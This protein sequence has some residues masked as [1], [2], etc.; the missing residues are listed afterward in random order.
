MQRRTGRGLRNPADL[1][2][3]FALIVLLAAVADA[4]SRAAAA[5]LYDVTGVGADDVLNMR[6][7]VAGATDLKETRIV[8][9]IPWN[10]RG[11]AASGL[12][13]PVRGALWRQVRYAGA[14]GWVSARYLTPAANTDPDRRPPAL[15]CAGTEP[16]WSLR[17]GP[18][19]AVFDA[20]L[21]D[22][23]S[24]W[25]DRV[26]SATGGQNRPRQW[27]YHLGPEDHARR[28]AIV[29]R[30]NACSD[31]MSDWTYPF[32]LILVD[33]DAG[34][35]P[36]Q[37][38]CN[39]PLPL[40]AAVAQTDPGPPMDAA[41]LEAAIRAIGAE[42]YHDRH[43]FH[44]M[45][46]GG[47]CSL[48]QVQ[49]WVLNR[50]YYQSRI[51]LKDAALLS[52]LEDPVL[53]R[54]WRT[55]I[56]EHDGSADNPGGIARWLVLAEAVG[57]DRRRRGLD[58]GRPAGHPLCGRCL[59][60]LRA[61]AHGAGGHRLVA[62]RAFRL[63]NPRGSHR[64]AADPLRLRHGRDHRLLPPPSERGPQGR[65]VQPR[66]RH[67]RG[68]KPGAAGPGP[69]GAALQDRR[70]VGPARCPLPCLRGPGPRAAGRFR[71]G[72]VLVSARLLVEDASVP[73]LSAGVRLH[74][75][76]RREQWVLLAPERVFVLDQVALEIVKRCDGAASMTTIVDDLA[77]AFSA[78]RAV[79]AKDVRDL[80]PGL[81]GQAGNGA[82]SAPGL[83]LAVL[84]ELTHRCP[85][86]CPYCS[87]PVVL[88]R[89]GAE[90][91]T[92][93]WQRV[94]AESAALGALQIHFSGGEPTARRD[95]EDMVRTARAEGLYQNLI[96]AGV[97][98][99]EARLAAL[100][101]AGIDHVQLSLQDS[102]RTG[103]ERIAGLRGAYDRKLAFAGQVRTL[104]LPLTLNFVVHRQNLDR[105][106]E[107]LDLAVRLDAQRV[108]IAH[109]QYHGW[110]LR[111]RAA[112]MP[113]R[114]Q[115]DRALDVVAAARERLKGVLVIDHVVPDYHARRPKA[116]M[117]GWGRRFLTITPSGKV[118]PCH[119]AETIADLA[120]ESVAEQPLRD[121]W[122]SS[123]AFNRYRGTAWMSE[124][125]RSCDRREMDWGGC[126]CQAFAL[127]GDAGKTDPA[128][129]LSLDRHLVKTV[130]EGG[131]G[132]AAT[133]LVYRSFADEAAAVRQ[134]RTGPSD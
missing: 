68:A 116:C 134:T 47:T 48:G 94:I 77:T 105:L 125:C 32:D 28:V 127:T 78:P 110:A 42:R 128:C 95:L 83:P 43:P 65:G 93:T 82:V 133:E 121:I 35:A 61:R 60:P 97:Q 40:S 18:G 72:F 101:E 9:R 11:V 107:M 111:N 103:C 75:D 104:G 99:S 106:E 122:E 62:D 1:W 25:T 109:V 19:E 73:K 87:N 39:L 119:A 89:S 21:A 115:F 36:L 37:G 4:P 34:S 23:S 120:F 56:E 64:R 113:R 131:S 7:N 90:L 129:A 6:N 100:A 49:A 14:T 85:L 59:H 81:R 30:T 31:G 29:T 46:H 52:R 13:T 58:R 124:P 45:L 91:D 27:A 55:R 2:R 118:L 98:V 76:T 20:P 26:L 12:T 88:E 74:F 15:S 51:P 84:A 130:A 69:G 123:E 126:R 71:T 10:A 24:K 132:T 70:P 22:V 67:P 108:E 112:L 8:G 33:V 102:E 5:D 96:T 57:L 114:D 92:A 54:E 3:A 86:Q 80:A 17:I 44:R 50:Y 66:L 63:A 53:R 79:I 16:F 41:E 117:G 38:C